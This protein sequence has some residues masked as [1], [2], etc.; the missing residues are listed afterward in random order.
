MTQ[1]R[2]HLKDILKLTADEAESIGVQLPEDPSLLPEAVRELPLHEQV[3][4]ALTEDD[5]AEALVGQVTPESRE[6]VE[7]AFADL[8]EQGQETGEE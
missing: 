3:A 7:D 5:V 8:Q 1:S 6:E 2:T 4:G